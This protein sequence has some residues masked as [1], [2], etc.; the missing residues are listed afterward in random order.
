MP[1]SLLK[2]CPRAEGLTPDAELLGRFA[3]AR[4]EAAF[5]ELV[6][7]HGPVVY[8]VC[9]R[10]VPAAADDAFQAVFLVLACRGGGTRGPR[11]GGGGRVA[12][13]RAAVGGWLAGVAGRVA[14]KMRA[15][16]PRRARRERVASRP[17]T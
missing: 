1:V 15:A 6:R 4:D 5:T 2:L 11:G 10:L 17:E 14:R 13:G 3:A 16:E 9:R 8:R 12:G 7:R